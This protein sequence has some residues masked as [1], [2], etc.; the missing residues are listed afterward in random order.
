MEIE[1]LLFNQVIDAA[2]LFWA[3]RFLELNIPSSEQDK[4]LNKLMITKLRRLGKE[5]MESSIQ[6]TSLKSKSPMVEMEMV[7]KLLGE[8]KKENDS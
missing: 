7:Q 3:A 5:V 6:R 4:M 1:G 2:H 8:G